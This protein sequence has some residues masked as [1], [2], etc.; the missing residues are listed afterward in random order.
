MDRKSPT[1]RSF[2]YAASLVGGVA[3]AGIVFK[4][5]DTPA[6]FSHWIGLAVV[7]GAV[8]LT[9]VW[10]RWRAGSSVKAR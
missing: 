10:M 7:V 4:V 9:D 8:V 3:A 6:T 1:Y 5:I 2:A